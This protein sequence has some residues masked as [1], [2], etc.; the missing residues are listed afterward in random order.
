MVERKNR[1]LIDLARTMFEEYKT[2]DWFWAE[3]VNMSCHTIN[4][5]Y[6]HKLLNKTSYA[7]QTSKKFNVSYFIVFGRKCY[8]LV[9]KGRNSKFT[10]ITVEGF[11]YLVKIQTQGHI[12]SSTNL[13]YLLKFLVMLC[14][15]KL[16]ALKESKLIVM[17]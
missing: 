9:K 14:L 12:E 7:L 3:A 5:L 11:Y 1:T 16:M 17:K 4:R 8:I 2:S 15:T 6:L 10:P 13:L